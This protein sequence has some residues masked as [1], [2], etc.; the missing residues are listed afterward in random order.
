MSGK[1]LDFGAQRL[2][3]LFFS[4]HLSLLSEQSEGLSHGFPAGKKGKERSE[5]N[6]DRVIFLLSH[7]TISA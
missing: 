2:L 1:I 5:K 3:N 6:V 4:P 7:V